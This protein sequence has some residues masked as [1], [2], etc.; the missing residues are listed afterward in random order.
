MMRRG[1][2]LDVLACPKCGGRL[3]LLAL[4][5]ERNTARKL[6]AHAHLPTDPPHPIPWR[7]PPEP[8]EPFDDV[9]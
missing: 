9:A 1:F 2:G 4:I 3:R 8:E 7:G 5:V 6:L